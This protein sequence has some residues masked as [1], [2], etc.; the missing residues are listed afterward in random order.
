MGLSQVQIRLSGI[1]TYL[2]FIF[3]QEFLYLKKINF[4]CFFL[5]THTHTHTHKGSM[6]HHQL[7]SSSYSSE[8]KELVF[9]W[10]IL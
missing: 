4:V 10:F 2:H 9:E 5:H 6:F 7:I 1:R 3:M 8:F